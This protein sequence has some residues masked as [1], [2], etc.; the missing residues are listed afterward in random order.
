AGDRYTARYTSR[1][2]N[3]LSVVDP[4]FPNPYTPGELPRVL[5]GRE[6]QKERIRAYIGRIV[7][8]GEMGGPLLVFQGPRG[9]G[10]TSLLGDAQRDA[11]EHGFLTAW[12]SCRRNAGFLPD[13]VDR[14]DLAVLLS[15]VQNLAG[16]RADNPPSVIA[17]GLPS[18]PAVLTKAAAFGERSS[19]ITVP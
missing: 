11:E 9:L 16:Q 14:I 17:A 18:T 6:R 19:F 3:E 13:L 15:A 7:A 4:V 1:M 10:K 12:I 8:F 5:A 2:C